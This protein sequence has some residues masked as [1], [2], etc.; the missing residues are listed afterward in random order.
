LAASLT[1]YKRLTYRD[2]TNKERLLVELVIR[3]SLKLG[4][5]Y[6]FL[7]GIPLLFAAVDIIPPSIPEAKKRHPTS[8]RVDIGEC[9][10][11]TFAQWLMKYRVTA[12]KQ[13]SA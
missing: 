1:P 2:R 11:S 9:I 6:N 4:T 8:E 10:D 3:D 13:I 5:Q 7:D 12:K